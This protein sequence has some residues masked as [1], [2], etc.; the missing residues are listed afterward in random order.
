[1]TLVNMNPEDYTAALQVSARWDQDQ[2]LHS[3]G[4]FT[5]LQSRGCNQ[6]LHS[7][8]ISQ[9]LQSRGIPTVLQCRGSNQDYIVLSLKWLW[10][11]QLIGS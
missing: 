5:V 10:E 1:M 8:G 11:L 2:D 9:V 3:R 7:R 6:D 4:I